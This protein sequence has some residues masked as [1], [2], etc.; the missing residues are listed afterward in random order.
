MEIEWVM[1]ERENI[2]LTTILY[3][4]KKWE[5]QRLHAAP[6]TTQRLIHHQTRRKETTTREY[7]SISIYKILY[8]LVV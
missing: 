4:G 3:G 7:I 5:S 8:V 2:L 6:D 1:G